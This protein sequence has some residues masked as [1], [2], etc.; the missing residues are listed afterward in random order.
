MKKKLCSFL[1]LIFVFALATAFGCKSIDAKGK[2]SNS[3]LN[4][5]KIYLVKGKSFQLKVLNKKGK[6][7]WS[8][9]KPAVVKVTKKGKLKA[10]KAGK[11]VIRAKL[12]GKTLKCTVVVMRLS[13]TSVTIKQGASRKIKVL[14]GTKVEWSSSRPD[15]AQV[16]N[17]KI[18]ALNPGKTVVTARSCGRT[19]KCTVRVPYVETAQK[20]LA[21]SGGQKK[22]TLIAKYFKKKPV[23][24]SSDPSIASVSSKGVVKA[25]KEGNA[26]ITITG[27]KLVYKRKIKVV[28]LSEESTSVVL[29]F[30]KNLTLSNAGSNVIW[31]SSN[32]AV[33]TVSGGKISPVA[34]GSC[35]ITAQAG[36]I[37]LSCKVKVVTSPKVRF[38][39]YL[40]LYNSYIKANGNYF[41]R[42]YD[43]NLT[44][45]AK[46][47][48]KVAAKKVAGIT[49]VVPIRWA[50][51]E[52]DIRRGDGKPMINADSGSF[53]KYKCYSGSVVDHFN[54]ITSGGA[55]GKTF[56]EAV[57][58]NLLKPGDII[59]FKGR[60][61]TFVYSGEG[62]NFYDGGQAAE[63]KGYS[64]VGIL[65]DY[66]K[67]SSYKK[68]AIS[69][70]LRW[71]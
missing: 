64:K 45:F 6:V 43:T 33:A 22:V 39:S 58:Q 17:G 30:T 24:K 18:T 9:S 66:T 44:S 54:W 1:L 29:G 12:K 65:V 49:C 36:D 16:V 62:Y 2:N 32:N 50:L 71:K 20:Y 4:Q 60:T 67:V 38:L 69:E 23:F 35:T 46:A 61:H 19:M 21:V 41:K 55:I 11:S 31:S 48:E 25:K 3:K 42:H 13:E 51:R 15:V 53:K 47:K 70:I 14:K 68:V 5:K 63:N 52:L 7:K 40:D 59:T 57:D 28:R 34:G 8:S 37:T 56:K 10:L 27:D 26:T